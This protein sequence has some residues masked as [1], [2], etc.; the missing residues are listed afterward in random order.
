VGRVGGVAPHL[1][2]TPQN[3]VPHISILRCGPGAPFMQPHRMSGHSRKKR[4]PL[5]MRCYTMAIMLKIGVALLSI[6]AVPA[7]AQSIIP[8]QPADPLG[9]TWRLVETRQVLADGSVRPDP[10]LG[11][12]PDGFMIYDPAAGQMCTVFNDTTRPRW[13]GPRPTDAELRTLFDQ[14]VIYCSRYRVD[15]ARHVI[16]FDM[17]VTLSPAWTGTSRER[18]FELSGDRLTLYP[19]PLPPGVTAWSIH[20]ERV[21]R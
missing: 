4:E 19:T 1:K 6:M 14:T 16:G 5:S 11:P 17:E 20:L 15:P 18:H 3:R 21:R 9:G 13:A 10:D 12:K 7:L 8:A 2:V